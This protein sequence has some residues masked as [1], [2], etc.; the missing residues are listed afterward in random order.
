MLPFH[1]LVM[2]DNSRLPVCSLVRAAAVDCFARKAVRI[3]SGTTGAV[4]LCFEL[5]PAAA[6]YAQLQ[7]IST[8]PVL[9]PNLL[10]RAGVIDPDFCGAINALFTFM[11]LRWCPPAFFRPPFTLWQVFPTA[12]G[13]ELQDTLR[14]WKSS[15]PALILT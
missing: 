15:L 1:R 2:Y 11:W 13:G 14:P 3:A 5:V 4:P 6:V 9:Q 10:F 8:M 7:E 12:E